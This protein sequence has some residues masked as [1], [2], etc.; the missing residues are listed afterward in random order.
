MHPR[1]DQTGARPEQRAGEIEA[2]LRDDQL[3][4]P[5]L[6]SESMGFGRLGPSA[7]KARSLRTE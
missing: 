3:A 5:D 1:P 4:A 7:Q 2:A 6:V